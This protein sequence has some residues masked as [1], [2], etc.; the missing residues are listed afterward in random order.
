MK[1]VESNTM[2][3]CIYLYYSTRKLESDKTL[4]R[5]VAIQLWS[6]AVGVQYMSQYWPR[7]SWYVSKKL[8]KHM[9]WLWLWQWASCKYH[10]L[11]RFYNYKRTYLQWLRYR[12][13]NSN[14][15][16]K[17]NKS[18]SS[19][20]IQFLE[21]D[22]KNVHSSFVINTFCNKILTPG[23]VLEKKLTGGLGLF[24]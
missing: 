3:I 18:L 8:Y 10:I 6:H 23:R 22:L 21:A 4:F 19:S 1:A 5:L 15:G 11:Q 12:K 7:T 13:T 24:F 17:Q 20:R 9:L 2:H 16:V 14:E